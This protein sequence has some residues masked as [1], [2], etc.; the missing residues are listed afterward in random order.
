M[1]HAFSDL[2]EHALFGTRVFRIFENA[3]SDFLE[4]AV[5]DFLEQPFSDFL[6]HAF[7][8]FVEHAYHT[9]T[10]VTPNL[11]TLAASCL[12]YGAQVLHPPTSIHVAT[13]MHILNKILNARIELAAPWRPASDFE[14]EDDTLLAS[15]TIT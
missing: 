2:L 5:S 4:H 12:G 10:L 8:N 13:E 11:T 15:T 1:E 9:W 3:F 6:E 7:S 14:W